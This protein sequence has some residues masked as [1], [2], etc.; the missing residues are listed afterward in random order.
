[1]SFRFERVKGDKSKVKRQMQEI[2]RLCSQ[3]G[4]SI[5]ENAFNQPIYLKQHKDQIL[6]E[7]SADGDNI[8]DILTKFQISIAWFDYVG[9]K[10]EL[11]TTVPLNDHSLNLQFYDIPYDPKRGLDMLYLRT[12]A[13]MAPQDN[14]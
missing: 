7:I 12:I 1:M 5:R 3:L 14:N 10:P 11:I 9:I 8:H 13:Q 4:Y 6:T 2:G